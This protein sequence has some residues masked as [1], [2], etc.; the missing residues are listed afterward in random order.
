MLFRASMCVYVLLCAALVSAAPK[1][2]VTPDSAAGV[3][4]LDQKVTWSIRIADE[5]A[6]LEG[7]LDYTI[8]SGGL[9]E[10]AQ[11]TLDLNEGRAQVS[12]SRSNPGTLLLTL[13]YKPK[14][15]DKE[16][17]A[18]GGAVI[19]PDK[20]KASSAPPDDFDAFW[21]AKIKELDAVDM[22]VVLTPAD[23]GDEH[24]EYFTLRMDNIRGRKIYGQLARPRGKTNLPAL[25]QVQWAGV[26][27]LQRDWITGYAKSGWLV[28]NISAHDLPINQPEQFYKDQAAKQL[29]DYPG[30]GNDDRETSYF[31]PMFLSC[32]RAVDYLTKHNS[33][34][35]GKTMVV[36]GGSQ[37]GYQAIVTA[38]LHPAVTAFAAN[39]P[40]GCD[41][42][43]KTAG[44]A[45]GWP[46]WAGR[47][48]KF[49]DEQREAEQRML[50]TARYFDAMNFA[51]R[52]KCPGVIGIGLIDTVCPAEGIFATCNQLQGPKEVVVMPTADHGGD[53]RA[54]YDA[55]GPFLQR[56]KSPS[57][58]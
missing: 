46:Q 34:W 18:L 14:D 19:A 28:L 15:S 27:P 52:V 20:I 22:N 31:L 26:Y 25:L 29:N 41:H 43:G 9:T 45:P 44:R 21:E 56:H 53:H 38:G 58:K 33:D 5:G 47:S 17:T 16:L 2:E 39:V 24:V 54:Y 49:K 36:I 42:T 10:I 48:W 55:M 6:S 51:T 8:K 1:I 12:G 57:T 3:Y 4:E 23:S 35:N 13:R 7:K 50:T 11:G 37:G 30:I 32:R 40:A